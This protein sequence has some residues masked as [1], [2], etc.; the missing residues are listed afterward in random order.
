[1]LWV[2]L[3]VERH[4]LAAVTA[5][6]IMFFISFVLRSR[7]SPGSVMAWILFLLV[8]P[9]VAIPLYLIITDRKLKKS[10]RQPKPIAKVRTAASD[11]DG[12]DDMARFILNLGLR[13]TGPI[14]DVQ[15][16]SSGPKAL[17]EMLGLIRSAKT[18]I[19][20]TIYIFA[21]D[22]V[23][24]EVL[25]ELEIKAQAGVEVRVLVDTMGV[26]WTRSP[27]FKKLKKCGG[28]V[29][30]FMPLLHNPMHGRTNLR[31]HRKMILIDGQ[32]AL[33]GGMNIAEEYQG[34]KQKRWIDLALKMRGDGVADLEAIFQRDWE[35]AANGTQ[36]KTVNAPTHKSPGHVQ[37]IA[38]G[39]D[40]SNDALYD[41]YL[42]SIYK[43][44]RR[45]WIATPYFVPDESLTKGLEL[46][47]RRGVDV[48]LWLPEHSDHWLLDLVRRSYLRHLFPSGLCIHFV[49]KLM[50]GK[51][52]IVDDS[53]AI[54]GS[55]NFDMRSLI[56]NYELEV[57]VFAEREIE[58]VEKWFL[59]LPA[60]KCLSWPREN[61]F[62]I[63]IEGLSRLLGPVL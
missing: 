61:L 10:A 23:G 55:A 52:F 18:S 28:E 54:V 14:D 34:P 9:Y 2:K 38:S 29:M 50:H 17:T 44:E 26:L 30:H 42:T 15:L 43:A 62:W 27:S 1:M 60:A 16:V 51:A 59:E 7:R 6:A 49:S 4:L 31:N 46:A 5:T 56:Y 21:N 3:W 13:P 25:R 24:R 19:H 41:F 8:L 57:V 63:L 48:K 58:D 20:I 12:P 11:F 35:F 22:S 45:I 47:A 37:F 36:S 33:V 40:V 53:Y 32:S 39:P